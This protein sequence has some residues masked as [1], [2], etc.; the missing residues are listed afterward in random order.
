[1]E[2]AKHRFTNAKLRLESRN[3]LAAA[4]WEYLVAYQLIVDAIP[5]HRDYYDK[6]VQSRSQLHRDYKLLI[7]VKLPLPFLTTI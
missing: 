5:R 4:Y 3:S 7:K 1:M 2:G 6:I